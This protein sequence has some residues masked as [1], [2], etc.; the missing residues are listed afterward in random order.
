VRPTHPVLQTPFKVDHTNGYL[1]VLKRRGA[2]QGDMGEALTLDAIVNS[3]DAELI[4][5]GLSAIGPE[6][7][8]I[9]RHGRYTLW[10]FGGGARLLT[11]E[12]RKLFIN[13]M[14]YA[15]SQKD[16]PVLERRKVSKT[17]D[18]LYSYLELARYKVPGLLR[19]MKMYVPESMS[20]ASI[21]EMATWI[22]SNRSYFYS[23]G[24]KVEIDQF[25]KGMGIPNHRREFLE[26]CIA[27]IHSG[28]Q[29]EDSL[30]ALRR[31]TGLQLSP[32][33]DAWQVWYDENGPYIYFSDCGGY[34]FKIDEEAKRKKIPFEQLRKWSSEKI[35]YRA[36]P[37][38]S[39][40]KGTDG[41]WF[42][43]EM[44]RL[45]GQKMYLKAG[46][47]SEAVLQVVTFTDYVNSDVSI[48]TVYEELSALE[49][50]PDKLLALLD[51]KLAIRRMMA[52]A[53]LAQWDKSEYDLIYDAL[54]CDSTVK[55]RAQKLVIVASTSGK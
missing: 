42:L 44:Q 35:D 22:D 25:A 27:N 20:G 1:K 54:V 28:T 53:L 30:S 8:A 15:A 38:C 36:D 2:V 14:Y 17:R 12:G 52:A 34:L 37:G 19:T 48:K 39:K 50:S 41:K 5:K 31:Y 21:D 10:G 16:A 7:G 26:R 3:C 6:R 4:A 55:Q 29:V 32:D 45:R 23:T 51:D 33:A 18:G 46:M 47:L 43:E 24:R 40:L 9:V 49:T 11:T 13:T